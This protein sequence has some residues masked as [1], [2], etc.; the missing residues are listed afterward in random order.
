MGKVYKSKKGSSCKRCKPHKAGW[1]PKKK[2]KVRA[3]EK[4]LDA[5]IMEFEEGNWTQGTFKGD[6]P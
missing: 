6:W 2:L 1:S 5:D 4:F 3:K